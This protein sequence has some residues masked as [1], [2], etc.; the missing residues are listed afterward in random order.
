V[1]T[2]LFQ[3]FSFVVLGATNHNAEV[4]FESVGIT[5]AQ[6]LGRSGGLQDTRADVKG[7][8][9]FRLEDPAALDPA[10]AQ[11][12]RTTPDGKVPVIY[13]VDLKNPA[14]FFVAQGFP[15]R[16][17]DVLYVSNAPIADLQKFVNIVSTM[18]FSVAGVVNVVP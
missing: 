7:V 12:A 9:I 15:I 6:A 8:F 5:L 16:N 3:P 10:V 4:P 1:V 17:K 11:G 2:A 14:S 13:R 18:A